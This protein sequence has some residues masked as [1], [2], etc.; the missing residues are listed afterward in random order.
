MN[1][2]KQLSPEKIVQ[3]KISELL[4]S[5]KQRDH[6][7]M[8]FMES[9]GI[10]YKETEIHVSRSKGAIATSKLVTLKYNEIVINSNMEFYSNGKESIK[11]ISSIIAA[12]FGQIIVLFKE[13]EC[14]TISN[15]VLIDTPK[16]ILESN[17]W[18]MPG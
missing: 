15:G 5:L 18:P 3:D 16:T 12:F 8:D 1:I 10:I 14:V 13:H 7:I 6:D 2:E 11:F 17:A 4:D 9:R